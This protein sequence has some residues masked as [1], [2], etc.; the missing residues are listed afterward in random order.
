MGDITV[1]NGTVTITTGTVTFSE[2]EEALMYD[3]DYAKK[4]EEMDS[5]ISIGAAQDLKYTF[6]LLEPST[7]YE[8]KI[9]A[10]NA[11]GNTIAEGTTTFTT[12]DVVAGLVG[13]WYYTYGDYTETYT[14]GADAKGTRTTTGGTNEKIM[15]EAEEVALE[16]EGELTIRTFAGDYTGTSTVKTVKYTYYGADEAMKIDGTHYFPAR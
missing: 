16:E 5:E 6:E 14:F 10:L 4:G 11:E 3:V 1:T 7:E 8:V 9:S 12:K 15:W 2:V 13:E